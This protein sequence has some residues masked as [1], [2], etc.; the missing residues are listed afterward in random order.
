[1]AARKRGNA[2]KSRS[3]TQT[4]KVSAGRGRKTGKA[5]SA[6]KKSSTARKTTARRR[7]SDIVSPVERDTLANGIRR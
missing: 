7:A 3:G 2:R 1:M 6:R 5:V 4:T